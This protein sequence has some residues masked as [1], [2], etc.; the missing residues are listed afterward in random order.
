[1]FNIRDIF[2]YSSQTDLRTFRRSTLPNLKDFFSFL[3][4]TARKAYSFAY[5]K[6]RGIKVVFGID[7]T[8]IV[9]Y[10]SPT[11]SKSKLRSHFNNLHFCK[12]SMNHIM[13]S[14]L[15]FT[16]L[17]GTV[18]EFLFYINREAQKKRHR[19][20]SLSNLMKKDIT[21]CEV[22]EV[23]G[24]TS[25]QSLI[26]SLATDLTALE[27]FAAVV[28]R[29]L[30]LKTYVSAATLTGDCKPAE[31][32]YNEWYSVMSSFK[33]R[34]RR[35]VSNIA[36]ST[37]LAIIPYVNKGNHKTTV[38]LVTRTPSFYKFNDPDINMS[39]SQR[40]LN[41]DVPLF[42]NPSVTSLMHLIN[43]YTSVCLLYT[44]PSPRD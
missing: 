33:S 5:L 35:V 40:I 44:S 26:H 41:H 3:N 13:D 10:C 27:S 21:C 11:S 8:E 42:I 1:M 37:N 29:M 38:T 34:S 23:A 9:G 14:A 16:I 32:K 39:L 30:S 19:A 7:L 36:D 2:S 25:L 28:N 12:T 43:P 18:Y 17:P 24:N 31:S 22:L 20:L 6:Q 15:P 4:D